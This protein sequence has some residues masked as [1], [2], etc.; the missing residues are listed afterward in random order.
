MALQICLVLVSWTL[1]PLDSALGIRK[2]NDRLWQLEDSVA[3]L[4]GTDWTVDVA[5]PGNGLRGE[6]LG[7][8]SAAVLA[9]GPSR[10]QAEPLE[11][12]EV[13]TRGSDLVASYAPTKNFPFR[14][15]LYWRAEQIQPA[16]DG[17]NDGNAA[18]L[19]LI[20]SVETDLL[21]TWPLLSVCSRLEAAAQPLAASETGTLAPA[22][23]SNASSVLIAGDGVAWFEAVHPSDRSEAMLDCEPDAGGSTSHWRLFSQFL[24]KGVIRRA[25]VAAALLPSGEMADS[26]EKAAD[27]YRAFAVAE[28][29]LTV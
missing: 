3:S 16:S 26:I 11:L 24:E 17:S 15:E 12:A 22:E 28:P 4:A 10:P 13:Y 23:E 18:R 14:T 7:G 2:V 19:T 20:A 9:V 1:H 25:R 21:D 29:P 6:S 8:A 5:R 27:C